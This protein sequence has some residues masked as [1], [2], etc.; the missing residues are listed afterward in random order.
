[1]TQPTKDPL[2]K[3][4]IINL[5]NQVYGTIAEIGGGQETARWFFR[6]G[7]AAGTVAKSMSAYDMKFSDAIYG[8]SPRYVSR[9]RLHS[10]LE[11]EY[12]LIVANVH[13]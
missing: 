12:Q 13:T 1:M 7:G 5:D 9:E 2:Q 6:A 11:H 8:H 3:A 10:M 4:L